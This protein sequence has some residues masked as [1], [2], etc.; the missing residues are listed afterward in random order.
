V[1]EGPPSWSAARLLRAAERLTRVGLVQVGTP[2]RPLR[3]MQLV[4]QQ[5]AAIQRHR[6]KHER[7]HTRLLAKASHWRQRAT[8]PYAAGQ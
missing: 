7:V 8:Q 4:L 5:R 6:V 3:P 2:H 1:I